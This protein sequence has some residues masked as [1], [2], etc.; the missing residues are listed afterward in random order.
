MKLKPLLDLASVCLCRMYKNIAISD[1]DEIV[2]Y[3]ASCIKSAK[4]VKTR[5]RV[6]MWPIWRL[7]FLYLIYTRFLVTF[8]LD[9]LF[10]SPNCSTYCHFFFLA[11]KTGIT[12]IC[13]CYWT[14]SKH[15]FDI[16]FNKVFSSSGN[17]LCRIHK[18]KICCIIIVNIETQ[19]SMD[20]P[21]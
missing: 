3:N 9:C 11:L 14:L 13:I 20:M 15:L 19:G 8:I 1:Q 2:K 7:D 18:L 6:I 21:A 17:L 10:C 16:I 5:L 12:Y 4:H